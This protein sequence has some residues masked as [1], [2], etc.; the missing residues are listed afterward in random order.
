MTNIATAA[1][2]AVQ[3]IESVINSGNTFGERSD[4]GTDADA[5][6]PS[7]VTSDHRRGRYVFPRLD[8]QGTLPL[9]AMLRAIPHHHVASILGNTI[10]VCEKHYSP[11]TVP[12]AQMGIARNRTAY[13]L[14]D[15]SY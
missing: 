15:L 11:W 13:P 1:R 2:A 7:L 8:K 10:D 9:S 5:A 12:S 3:S 14:H 4:G 6:G